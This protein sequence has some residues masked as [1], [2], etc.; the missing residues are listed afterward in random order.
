MKNNASPHTFCRL[1]KLFL[2]CTRHTVKLG[3]QQ[4]K[5]NVSKTSITESKF[6]GPN[7]QIFDI[8]TTLDL[9][10]ALPIFF[11]KKPQSN[12]FIKINKM[13]GGRRGASSSP[14]LFE[15]EGFAS[16]P[17]KIWGGD[18]PTT[19]GG[20]GPEMRHYFYY[21]FISFSS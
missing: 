18:S 9:K 5:K 12:T 7:S 13:L 2:N 6:L 20:D 17:A 11:S 4:I 15:G 3:V 16:I 1:C 14:R 19:L 21:F 10:M 8:S